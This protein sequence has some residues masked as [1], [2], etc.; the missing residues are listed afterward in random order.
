M[1]FINVLYN[2][3]VEGKEFLRKLYNTTNAHYFVPE[4]RA[5]MEKNQIW[6]YFQ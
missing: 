5:V 2:Y 4:L 3:N 1:E 6:N